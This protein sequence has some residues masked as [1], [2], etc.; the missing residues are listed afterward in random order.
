MPIF[1]NRFE[2]VVICVSTGRTAT[3]ELANR[4]NR[5]Y[6]Q[7][8]AVHEPA[9]SRKLRALSNRRAAG[10]A[11]RD[12]LIRVYAHSRRALFAKI[13][14]P[15]YM[16]FNPFLHGFVDVLPELFD[17]PLFL[18]IVRDPRQY[19][20]SHLNHGAL[21]GLKGMAIR[22][23]KHYMIRPE[24]VEARPAKTWRQ[25]EPIERIAFRWRAVNERLERDGQALGSR[26]RRVAFE[27]LTAPDGAALRET[28]A[29]MGLPFVDDLLRPEQGKKNA[30]ARQLCPKWNDMS[31]AQR[32]LILGQCD[33][34]MARYGYLE[35]RVS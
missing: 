3:T 11:T 14:A 15:I 16:E 17:D 8:H 21:S 28:V 6:R 2:K 12:D 34:L 25:M 23:N 7:V 5:V 19:V 24:F 1:A 35:E 22:L 31:E 10:K 9:P 18:H 30:S 26:Y 32:R 33:G 20:P 13:N 27:A 4:F 29:W